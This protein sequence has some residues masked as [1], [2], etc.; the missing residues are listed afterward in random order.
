MTSRH[1]LICFL[2]HIANCSHNK[3]HHN[4]IYGSLN[5]NIPLGPPYNREVWGY[6][7][8][9]RVCM[10]HAISLVNWSNLFS[11]K[12]ADEKVKSL[13]NILLNMFRN[14]IP[15]KV[16]KVDYKHRNWMNSKIISYLRNMSKLTKRYYSNP[17]EENKNLTAKSNECSNMI[18]EVKERY[19]NKLSK[20]LDYP[21]TMPKTYWSVLNTFLNNKKNNQYS[22]IKCK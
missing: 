12:T 18:I 19:T 2:P 21:S 8:T 9:D 17:T 3:C 11:N 20:K 22:S 16:I 4:I 1:V 14:L 5:F 13:N 15:N 6:K 10:Q 7:N